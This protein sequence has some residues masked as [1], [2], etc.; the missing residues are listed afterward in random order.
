M[1]KSFRTYL[2]IWLLCAALY[3][4]IIF[5]VMGAEVFHGTGL[6]SWVSAVLMLVCQLAVM[7]RSCGKTSADAMSNV[8]PMLVSV[9]AAVIM[10]VVSFVTMLLPDTLWL[11]VLVICAVIVIVSM[12]ILNLATA[13]G[14]SV[15]KTGRKIKTDTVTIRTLTSQARHLMAAA[16]TPQEKAQTKAVYEALRYADPVSPVALYEINEQISG[17]FKAFSN[18]LMQ[19]DVEL[20]ESE[21][22]QLLVLI[23]WRGNLC[24]LKK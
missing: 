15:E 11:P 23:D 4:V 19:E 21:K 8:L 1:R 10:A 3:H 6:I 12:I 2:I 7:V 5:S 16:R 18:A 17:Q 24:A 13:A 20:A 9:S 22:Q 14:R